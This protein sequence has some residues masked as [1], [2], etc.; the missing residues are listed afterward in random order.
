[1]LMMK[2]RSGACW[3]FPQTAVRT[4]MTFG[5]TCTSAIQEAGGRIFEEAEIISTNRHH[6]ILFF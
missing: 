3:R 6:N 4:S 2:P 1:M 5:F